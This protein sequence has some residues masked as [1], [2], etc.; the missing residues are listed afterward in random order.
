MRLPLKSFNLA[1]SEIIYKSSKIKFIYSVMENG[2]P[3]T[4]E[5]LYDS[6]LST[7]PNSGPQNQNIIFVVKKISEVYLK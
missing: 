2:K 5:I 1:A 7:C 4:S 3:L 6:Y